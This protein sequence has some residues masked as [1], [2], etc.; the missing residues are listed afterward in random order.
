MLISSYILESQKKLSVISLL[1]CLYPWLEIIQ[2]CEPVE[3]HPEEGWDEGLLLISP[4]GMDSESGCLL[5]YGVRDY[6]HEPGGG[7]LG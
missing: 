1:I 3:G 4:H 2:H 7:V 5:R 6:E